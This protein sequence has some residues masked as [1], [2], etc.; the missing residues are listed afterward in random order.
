MKKKWFEGSSLI[1][2]SFQSLERAIKNHGK[3]YEGVVSCMSGISSVELLE[4]GKDYLIIKTNEGI[5]KRTEIKK[6]IEPDYIVIEF[7]EEYRAGK[8]VTTRS[9]FFDEFTST[10]NG[11][12]LIT[13]ISDVKA[14]GILGLAYRLF[15]SSS[16]GKAVL[17]SH[18]TYLEALKD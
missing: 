11:I 12:K 5:M 14:S 10:E 1:E 13:T 4:Q 18:K 2:Y 7:D 8:T 15:G 17:S 9:H 6:S 3:F 16:I